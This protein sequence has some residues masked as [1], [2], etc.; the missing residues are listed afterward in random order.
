MRDDKTAGR[1]IADYPICLFAHHMAE[2]FDVSVKRFY[3]LESEGAFL[4]AENRP[5]IGRKSWSRDRVKA[6]FDG[7]L[8]GLTGTKPLRR[9][10]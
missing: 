3:K 2:I 8:L 10:S 4:F 6:Y 5:R 1:A 9:A 7:T